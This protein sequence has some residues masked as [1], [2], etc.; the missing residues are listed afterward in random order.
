MK[1]L[2]AAQT[3]TGVTVG[4]GVLRSSVTPRHYVVGPLYADND[5]ALACILDSFLDEL[6]HSDCV[7]IR[8]P[9]LNVEKLQQA[10]GS[11]A[12]IKHKGEYIPQYT[13]GV[14]D[15]EYQL[16]YSITDFSAPI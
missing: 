6:E 9:S 8:T 11:R 14:P 5:T 12:K 15:F 7:E 4:Y 13:K 1:Y 2:Q 10:V 16:V 3:G